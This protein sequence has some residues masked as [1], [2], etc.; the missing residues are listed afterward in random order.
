MDVMPT[1]L[2]VACAEYPNVAHRNSIP[3]LPGI[4]LLPALDN[5]PLNRRTPIF[6]EHEDN[7]W[8]IDGDWKLVA[9]KIAEASG[10]Q[11]ERWAG[12]SSSRNR[13]VA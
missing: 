8:V 2:S 12:N 11:E 7:G 9:N 10:P 4:S 5:K 3:H 13:R 1:I 6:N